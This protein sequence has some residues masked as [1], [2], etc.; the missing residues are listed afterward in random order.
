LE[1]EDDSDYVIS[2]EDLKSSE[3]E[4][5]SEEWIESD[6]SLSDENIDDLLQM[7]LV[8]KKMFLEKVRKVLKTIRSP[9]KQIN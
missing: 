5:E 3:S 9:V 4:G 8:P 1:E 7:R 6:K 2:E